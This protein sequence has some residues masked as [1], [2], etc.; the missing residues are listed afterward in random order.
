[1]NI[2]DYIVNNEEMPILKIFHN[3]SNR[4][5]NNIE[6][7]LEC[8]RLLEYKFGEVCDPKNLMK[9]YY[10]GCSG[11]RKEKYDISNS[12]LCLWGITH[13]IIK[14]NKLYN[15]KSNIH[16]YFEEKYLIHIKNFYLK[17]IAKT[18]NDYRQVDY[19]YK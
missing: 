16:P 6:D 17:S 5:F 19:T 4:V 3:S 15:I 18:P 12:S 14:Y 7:I 2:D 13:F 1:M 10:L 11:L 9:S 8:I